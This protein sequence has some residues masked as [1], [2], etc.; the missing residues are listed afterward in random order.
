MRHHTLVLAA[1][2]LV[3]AS[4]A[5]AQLAREDPTAPS[6]RRI[7]GARVGVQS[8]AAQAEPVVGELIAVSTD[9]L[10]V[11]ADTQLVAMALHDVSGLRVQRHGTGMGATMTWALIGGVVTGGALAGACSSVDGNN[12]CGGIVPAM[13]LVWAAVGGLAGISLQSSRFLTIREASVRAL[14]PY[15]RFPQGWPEGVD[16]AAV[17]PIPRN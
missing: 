2:L 1:S 17:R 16:R 10:W 15:A 3:I 5:Q 6:V 7:G 8:F 12:S 9:S 13:M 11:L 4:R 14:G